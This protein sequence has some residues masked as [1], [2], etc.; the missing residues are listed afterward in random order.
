MFKDRRSVNN[1]LMKTS[2]ENDDASRNRLSADRGVSFLIIIFF[3]FQDAQLFHIK[4]V[5]ASAD[6][7]GVAMFRELLSGLFKFRVEVF[8]FMHRFC[9]LEDM[10]P[11]RKMVV[12]VA[13]VPCVL[14]Q[15][16][17]VHLVSR[18]YG[19]VRAKPPT[20]SRL[21]A[22]HQNTEPGDTAPRFSTKLATGF[23]LALLFTYQ[24]L[25][26]TSFTLLNCVSVRG[27]TVLFVQGTVSCYQTWQY[28]VIAYAATCIVPFCLVLL[29]GPGL[30][31]DNVIRLREFFLACII[32]LPFL[33]RWIWIRYRL[34]GRHSTA[35][36]AA[37]AKVLP[38]ECQAVVQILQGPF[39]ESKSAFFGPICGQGFL[40]GRRLII[41]LLY[42]FVNDTLIR[43]L[44]MMLLCFV[45]L[46]HHVHVLPYKDERGNAAGSVSAA[47]LV[48][49][50]VI[51]LVRAGFEAAEYVPRG[52]NELLMRV[53]E[54]VENLLMLWLPG[55][56]MGFV[57]LTLVVKLSFI[58]VQNV[59]AMCRRFRGQE[60][61]V[62]AQET[63]TMTMTTMSRDL[64]PTKTAV[65]HRDVQCDT[66]LKM[67]E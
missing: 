28:A 53:L 18:W 54:E 56:V 37:E 25:A 48:V 10:T 45:L 9:F 31:K 52:P 60:N 36:A 12:R 59:L 41:V 38:P 64:N 14:A 16:G 20:N 1:L 23:V 21:S 29:I 65:N 43:M 57:I 62:N 42:T 49:L 13:L 63:T 44:C 17:V 40:I 3:Y 2:N 11:I 30:L 24:K 15:F 26:T 51:N 67:N 34:Y 4:T 66:Q 33:L 6:N 7:Q 55:A 22:I 35:A 27:G 39:K 46:L 5:F 61:Q 19:H 58:V 47:G 32:P 50:A 8:Q